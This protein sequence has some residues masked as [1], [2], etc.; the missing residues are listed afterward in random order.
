[1]VQDE[2]DGGETAVKERDGELP[3]ERRPNHFARKDSKS[4]TGMKGSTDKNESK[5]MV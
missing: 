2:M 4:Q 5:A 1:M 3:R